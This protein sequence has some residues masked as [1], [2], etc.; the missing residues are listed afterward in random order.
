MKT[1]PD[2]RAISAH[3]WSGNARAM[4]SLALELSHHSHCIEAL[5][6]WVITELS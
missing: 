4:R 5:P 6:K 2:E 3:H 1:H